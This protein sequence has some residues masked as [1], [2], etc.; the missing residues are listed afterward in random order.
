MSKFLKNRCVA[1][2]KKRDYVEPTSPCQASRESFFAPPRQ[3]HGTTR[4]ATP[5]CLSL[6]APLRLNSSTAAL[7]EVRIIDN[8]ILTSRKNNK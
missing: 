6:P 7:E 4:P 1:A 5:D 3:K 8:Q 2:A